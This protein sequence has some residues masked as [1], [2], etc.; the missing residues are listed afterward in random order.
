MDPYFFLVDF[1]VSKQNVGDGD[2]VAMSMIYVSVPVVYNFVHSST[3]ADHGYH[4]FG[5]LALFIYCLLQK[6]K[7][8]S[9]LSLVEQWG[10]YVTP[11]PLRFPVIDEKDFLSGTRVM[12]ALEKV[13]SQFLRKEFRRDAR[14]FLEDFVNCLLSTVASRLL[15]GQ[16][17]S[18]FCPAIAVGGDNFAPF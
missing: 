2:S 3:A 11:N 15:I 1:F 16:D 13:G 6:S 9:S 17:M 4:S 12:T 8:A 7:K 5:E 10:E 18:C 14:R